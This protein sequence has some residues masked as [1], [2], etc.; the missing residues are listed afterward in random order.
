MHMGITAET[1]AERYAISREDQDAFAVESHRRAAA[2]RSAG[3]FEPEIVPVATSNGRRAGEFASV[4]DHDLPGI[5][6]DHAAAMSL[7]RVDQ[8]READQSLLTSTN[9]AR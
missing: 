3:H 7:H 5:D 8:L 9:A 1:L 2:A 4:V 6:R